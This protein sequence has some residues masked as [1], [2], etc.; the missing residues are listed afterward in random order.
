MDP[1]A[2]PARNA[3]NPAAANRMEIKVQAHGIL[4]PVADK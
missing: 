1:T 3:A 2:D 4:P